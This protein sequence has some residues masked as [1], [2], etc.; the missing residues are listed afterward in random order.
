M[1]SKKDTAAGTAGTGRHVILFYYTTSLPL[2][3]D[4]FSGRTLCII[5]LCVVKATIGPL[6][7][8]FVRYEQKI[9][10]TGK[11]M[12]FMKNRKA[13][14][15]VMGIIAVGAVV[16]AGALTMRSQAAEKA[17]KRDL[18]YTYDRAYG[19]L[20]DC[21]N[22][23]SL[24]LDKSIYANT[25]TQ[26]NGLAARLMHESGLAKEALATLP[27]H[28]STMNN[29]SKYITQVGDFAMS[30][31]NRISGG[32]HIT[33]AEY[34]TIEKL[35]TY[36]QKLSSNLSSL[37]LDYTS[38]NLSSQ[39]KQTA[40]DFTNFPSLIY[41]GPFSDNIQRKN[42]RALQGKSDVSK[43]DACSIAAK[44]LNLSPSKL[45]SAADTAGN[46]P[47]WNFTSGTTTASVTKKGGVLCSMRSSREITAEKITM[48]AA[49][50][51]ATA[52]LAKCGYKDMQLTYW[53]KTDGRILFNF[54]YEENGVRCYPDLV[55]V[56]IAL[57]NGD[58]VELGATG[59]LMNHMSRSFPSPKYTKEAAQ[60]KVSS[61]LK[62]NNSRKVLV[63]T[64]GLN[65]VLCWEFSCIG[66]NGDRVLVYIN[67]ASGMEQQILILQSTDAGILV[68]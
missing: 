57:D 56:G 46:L 29:V 45:T 12:Y 39:L 7:L 60:K 58:V 16:T 1:F 42:P 5:L 33:E 6:C 14:A 31:S 62:V 51:K 20:R 47:L 41:D 11:V 8:S 26:Q 18:T 43:A 15:V 64:S 68:Q 23:I 24:T 9:S 10:G 59:Y 67:C 32:G 61:R 55:K 34:K 17:A 2:F 63:P 25:P 19:D 36:A 38:D 4:V 53:I 3:K 52:F 37:K 49:K 44:A 21:V 40:T 35:H 27:V 22:T 50:E 48:D 66:S 28:D 65:E 13:V 30:L 54:A